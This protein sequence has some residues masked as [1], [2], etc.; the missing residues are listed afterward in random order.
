MATATAPKATQTE[1]THHHHRPA[2]HTKV[3]H[4]GEGEANHT[5]THA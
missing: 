5:A 2:H 4:T 1:T 3:H